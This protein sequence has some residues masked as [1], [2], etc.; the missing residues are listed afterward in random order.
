MAGEQKRELREA[1]RSHLTTSEFKTRPAPLT[2][3]FA[4]VAFKTVFKI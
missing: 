1:K 4:P 3:G 2:D